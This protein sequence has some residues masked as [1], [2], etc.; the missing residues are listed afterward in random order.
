MPTRGSPRGAGMSSRVRSRGRAEVRDEGRG[1]ATT[2]APR[3][4]TVDHMLEAVLEAVLHSTPRREY[5]S[6]VAQRSAACSDVQVQGVGAGCRCSA[7]PS[8]IGNG[9]S[10]ARGNGSCP[11]HCPLALA[12]LSPWS[13]DTETGWGR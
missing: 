9:S 12:R 7:M 4:L 1:L 13:V 8:W 11:G 3:L 10:N 5:E 6:L 2:C